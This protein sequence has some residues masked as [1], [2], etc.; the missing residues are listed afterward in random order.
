MDY[1]TV[2]ELVECRSRTQANLYLGAGYRLLN[3]ATVHY[4]HYAKRPEPGQ[5]PPEDGPV[6]LRRGICYVLGRDVGTTHYEPPQRNKG[7]QS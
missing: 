1:N 4:N 3:I 5:P 7:A 2:S 6:M